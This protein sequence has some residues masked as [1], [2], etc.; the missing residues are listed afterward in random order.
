MEGH[1]GKDQVFS[2]SLVY[3]E[4]VE[5]AKHRYCEVL[6]SLNAGSL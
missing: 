3:G 6:T 1:G 4:A 2:H 5:R